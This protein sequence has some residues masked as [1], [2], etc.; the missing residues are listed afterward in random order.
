[1]GFSAFGFSHHC[2]V[3]HEE[4]QNVFEDSQDL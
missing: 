4:L 1:M 2:P 3:N